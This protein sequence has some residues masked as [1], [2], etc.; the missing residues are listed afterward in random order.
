MYTMS[1]S[2]VHALIGGKADG[3]IAPFEALDD[4]HRWNVVYMLTLCKGMVW[5]TLETCHVHA[6]SV[7]RVSVIISCYIVKHFEHTE[8]IDLF[9]YCGKTLA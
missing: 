9:S 3:I 6:S 1:V 4:I 8:A 5:Y 7:V 2:L